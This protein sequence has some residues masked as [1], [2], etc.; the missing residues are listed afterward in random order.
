MLN[1]W[2]HVTCQCFVATHGWCTILTVA[3]LSADSTVVSSAA[4][5]QLP[6]VLAIV[7]P[8]ACIFILI[9]AIILI[10]RHIHR[11]RMRALISRE[12]RLLSD[13]IRATQVGEST[14]QVRFDQMEEE[15]HRY[16]EGYFEPG[17]HVSQVIYR[18]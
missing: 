16:L 11:K 15:H 8:A 17:H 3:F 18:S 12:Q 10:C 6:L 9:P 14:L 13:D 4:S 2:K 1:S 7:I 5:G